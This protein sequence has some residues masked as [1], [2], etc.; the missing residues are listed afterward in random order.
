MKS[1]S[2]IIVSNY[3]D[4]SQYNSSFET[5]PQRITKNR[6]IIFSFESSEYEGVNCDNNR[7][8]TEISLSFSGKNLKI[9]GDYYYFF[10]YNALHVIMLLRKMIH[11]FLRKVNMRKFT[12]SLDMVQ[13]CVGIV[14]Y[15]I[16]LTGNIRTDPYRQN[17][18]VQVKQRLDRNL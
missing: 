12:Q 6:M 4:E 13:L 1:N 15:C 5:E 7:P 8:I 18:R 17:N 11:W 9:A 10:L 2:L 14:V 3:L 16:L